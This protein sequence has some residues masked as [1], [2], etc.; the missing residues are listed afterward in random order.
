MRDFLKYH[1][2]A[3]AFAALIIIL[4]ST[5]NLNPSHFDIPGFDKVA[6]FLEYALFAVLVFRSFM[7]LSS[8][9]HL[10]PAVLLSFLFIILFAVA[11]EFYQSYV[12]GR[13]SDPH[14][15]L[16]DLLGSSLILFFLWFRYK[17]Q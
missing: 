17:K 2:P 8:K 5:S 16:F 9:I 13:D 11:D 4:S 10:K 7:H 14:D 15:V 1:A 6:H 3:L 12:P